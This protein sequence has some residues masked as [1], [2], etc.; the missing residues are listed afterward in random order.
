MMVK[1]KISKPDRALI[2]EHEAGMHDRKAKPVCRLC[3]DEKG[4]K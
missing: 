2:A 4:S 3:A 1:P